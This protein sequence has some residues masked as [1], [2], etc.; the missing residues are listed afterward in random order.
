MHVTFDP[1]A[2]AA[3]IQLV[4]EIGP[5]GVAKTYPCDPREVGGMINLDFDSGGR[6]LG[7]EVL[8]ARSMLTQVV[9]D[10]AEGPRG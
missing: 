5:G 3:Y 7:I 1:A 4:E 9:L 6:L 10:S 2:N 8:G